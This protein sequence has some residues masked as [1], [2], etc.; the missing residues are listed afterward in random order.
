MNNKKKGCLAI[1]L[2]PIV[3]TVL[4]I[5]YALYAHLSRPEP[6]NNQ[7]SVEVSS[8]DGQNTENT[9]GVKPHLI[10]LNHDDGSDSSYYVK[11]RRDYEVN[12]KDET[13][14]IYHVQKLTLTQPKNYNFVLGGK[15]K[16][17][18]FVR[19]FIKVKGDNVSLKY[20]N[21]NIS[22]PDYSNPIHTTEL[23]EDYR[24]K[25]D[26]KELDCP[27]GPEWWE[28]SHHGDM[29]DA[30]ILFPVKNI[31]K[32]H[33]FNY[34]FYGTVDGISKHYEIKVKF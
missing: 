30:S 21:G 7:T 12:A 20:N 18:G 17:N 24:P 26:R 28:M 33:A 15:K 25:L 13:A 5:I 8:E 6:S 27:T 14:T 22:F 10:F 4:L 23:V 29:K 34:G 32:I 2:L 19:F 3:I 16:V 31:N 9:E 1:I 11:S